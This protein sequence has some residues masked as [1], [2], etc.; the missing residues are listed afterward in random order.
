MDTCRAI[1]LKGTVG[2]STRE[3]ILSEDQVS[4]ALEQREMHHG[5]EAKW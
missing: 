5:M 4:L 2:G 3:D 1:L